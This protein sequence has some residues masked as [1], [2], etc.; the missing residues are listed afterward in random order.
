MSKYHIGEEEYNQIKKRINLIWD[1]VINPDQDKCPNINEL[2][3]LLNIAN[4]YEDSIAWEKYKKKFWEALFEDL[5]L[6]K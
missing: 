5:K 4:N 6:D 1:L 3:K 2:N